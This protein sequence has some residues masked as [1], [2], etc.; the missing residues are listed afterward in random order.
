M[1]LE[2]GKYETKLYISELPM[3]CLE[4]FELHNMSRVVRKP[5]LCICENKDADQRL[6]FRYIHKTIPL[7][8]KISQISQISSLKPPSVAVQSLVT[9]KSVFNVFDHVRHKPFCAST[10]A[11]KMFEIT[12]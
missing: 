1:N 11:S 5:A 8:S 2:R 7:L 10:E 12:D 6:C 4:D 3:R 9:M